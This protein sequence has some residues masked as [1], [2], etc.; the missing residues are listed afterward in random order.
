[1]SSAEA[2]VAI[3]NGSLS[4]RRGGSVPVS[5]YPDYGAG[6]IGRVA[7]N[8]TSLSGIYFYGV[9][10][11][12]LYTNVSPYRL[13]YG[14]EGRRMSAFS[15]DGAAKTPAPGF[16]ERA[17]F[18]TDS[19]AA[20][21]LPLDPESDYWFWRYVQGGDPSFGHT[22]FTVDAPGAQAGDATL[23]VDLQGATS[24]TDGLHDVSVSLNGTAL[25]P[26]GNTAW[27]GVAATR[28]T[29]AVPAGVVL[30][31]G[32]QV[33]VTAGGAAGNIFYVDGF[34]LSY[35]RSYAAV[36]DALK[37]TVWPLAGGAK[38]SGLSNTT[39]RLLDVSDENDPRWITGASLKPNK[40]GSFDLEFAPAF[41]GP[42]VA[43]GAWG[44]RPPVGVR[45]WSDASAEIGAADLLIVSPSGSSWLAAAERLADL[46]R[47]EGLAVRVADLDEIAD[48]YGNGTATPKAVRAAVAAESDA[49][50]GRLRY[51]VLAGDGSV[52]YRNLLGFGDGL[53][54]ALHVSTPSGVFPADNRYGD[55]DGD[56]LPEIAVG[57]IP[58]HTPAELDAVRDKLAAYEGEVNPPWANNVL[59]LADQP[60]GGANF[61]NDSN[62]VAALLDD[63]LQPTHI[64]L[65]DMPL[66]AA[67]GLLTS[68]VA[69]G[70]GLINYF[71]HGALDRLAAGGLLRSSDVSGLG[72]GSKLPFM[73]A[74]TCALNRFTIPG[75]PSLGELLVA[76][77]GGGAAAVLSAS[78]VPHVGDSRTLAL[79]MYAQ[80]ELFTEPQS[81][82]GD[83]LVNGYRQAS[84]SVADWSLYDF[85]NLLG[86][87][88][89]KL[90]RGPVR[91]PSG[92]SA[93]G[94]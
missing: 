48:V 47:A 4:L 24:G 93:A 23:Y 5:W 49:G 58:V 11:P 19:F 71:G 6:T 36:G 2:K 8:P 33:E 91:P 3:A 16:G 28:A 39:V 84:Q 42:F 62:R 87:P 10:S 43:A 78:G 65:A 30:A 45:A 70:V 80:Q 38:V 72:N 69:S 81:R 74:M 17:H 57:R 83:W 88:S 90:V 35:T 32:N 92:G 66:A 82:L 7:V 68:S 94:E 37:F 14:V 46:R 40:Q 22:S 1:V 41:P 20:T 61:S 52:D 50:G 12:N 86:D 53:V 77:A 73:T 51:V 27:T 85:Y 29:F 67:R 31:G 25:A 75:V 9:A 54:P 21:V 13:D 44:W 55:L 64:H 59:M 34:D 56:G 63:R 18:E 15:V 76:N 79:R 26:I 89:M 60:D